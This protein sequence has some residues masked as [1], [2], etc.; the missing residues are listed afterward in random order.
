MHYFNYF[1]NQ[2]QASHS[3]RGLTKSYDGR[4]QVLGTK[5]TRAFGPQESALEL[6]SSASG[7]TIKR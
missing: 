7:Q 1:E 5:R 4:C 6:R 2:V 3:E